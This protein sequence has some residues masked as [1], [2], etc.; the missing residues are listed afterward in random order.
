MKDIIGVVVIHCFVSCIYVFL[1]KWNFSLRHNFMVIPLPLPEVFAAYSWEPAAAVVI[2]IFFVTSSPCGE[3]S[4][5][6]TIDKIYMYH[7][8][9]HFESAIWFLGI[10]IS[11]VC[12]GLFKCYRHVCL[13]L[14]N[15]LVS[16]SQKKVSYIVQFV[17]LTALNEPWALLNLVNSRMGHSGFI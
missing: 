12:P 7:K 6:R 14:N 13:L 1:W 4:Q 5:L 11:P 9:I 3:R 15:F 8:S 2:L 10:P 17:G 16:Y